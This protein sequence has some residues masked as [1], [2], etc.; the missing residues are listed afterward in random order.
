MIANS[1]EQQICLSGP[2]RRWLNLSSIKDKDTNVLLDAPL[3]P[4]GLFSSAVNTVVDRFLEANKQ[5]VA[6]KKPAPHMELNFKKFV[7]QRAGPLH[8]HL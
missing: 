1:V 8:T 6:F 3:S 7:M 5:A 4:S 2:L